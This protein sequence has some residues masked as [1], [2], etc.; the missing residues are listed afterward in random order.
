M[1][2]EEWN[3]ILEKHR[4][5]AVIRTSDVQRGLK[6]AQAVA[7]G[8][9]RLIEITWNSVTPRHLVETLQEQLPHCLIGA[10]TILTPQDLKEAI[11]ARCQFCFSPH[12][13]FKLLNLALDAHIPLIPGAL[14]P[15]EIL[16]AWQAGASSVKVFPID[17]VG[18]ERYLRH[19][20]VPL[21]KIPLIPTGGVT[22]ENADAFIEAGAIAV[23]LSSQLL[24][25]VAIK[26]ENWQKITENA[27]KVY[28]A[29]QGKILH[30]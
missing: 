10:G 18:G 29:C 9:I 25:K 28:Q 13:D 15:T 21:G 8:G 20:C 30:P 7:E 16:T 2:R 24:P 14:T 19:I 5:I 26:A 17:T 4:V 27:S 12:T 3:R 11:A 22:L 23:G 6:M 1:N